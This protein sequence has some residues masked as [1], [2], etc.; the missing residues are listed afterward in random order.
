MTR[1]TL[2]A[3][4]NA[5]AARWGDGYTNDLSPRF[6]RLRAC[7]QAHCFYVPMTEDSARSSVTRV[8]AALAATVAEVEAMTDPASLIEARELISDLLGLLARGGA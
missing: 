3:A 8:E 1:L 5:A 4:V 7:G 2:A 6:A